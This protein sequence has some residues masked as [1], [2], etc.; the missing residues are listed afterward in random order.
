MPGQVIQLFANG[1]GPVNNQPADGYPAPLNANQTTTQP[2]T[3]TIGG[4]PA[5]VEFC[6]RA[7]GEVI[8]QVNAVVPTGLGAG[9]QPIAISVG[10]QTS[11]SGVMIPVQ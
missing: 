6:G 11:P 7:P 2:C 3:V 10:G 5:T 4:Q 9:N 1:L 8:Y